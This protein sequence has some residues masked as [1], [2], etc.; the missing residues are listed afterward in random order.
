VQGTLNTDEMKKMIRG[1][2]GIDLPE[3]VCDALLKDM[4]YFGHNDITFKEFVDGLCT[5][6]GRPM[7]RKMREKFGA[8][9]NSVF[10]IHHVPTD[11]GRLVVNHENAVDHE[12][13]TFFARQIKGVC[14]AGVIL[15][16]RAHDTRVPSA[17]Y[18]SYPF[19]S[20]LLLPSPFALFRRSQ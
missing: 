10:E 18:C 11:S 19:G 17:V 1:M 13:D 16:R 20:V 15:C 9:K 5:G 6:R 12:Y 7:P 2:L 8:R 4:N 3:D 14:G